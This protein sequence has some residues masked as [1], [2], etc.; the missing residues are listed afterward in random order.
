VAIDKLAGSQ[1]AL[2]ITLNDQLIPVDIPKKTKLF[3]KRHFPLAGRRFVPE[4]IDQWIRR[5]IAPKGHLEANSGPWI[6]NMSLPEMEL[7]CKAYTVFTELNQLALL[8]LLVPH[9]RPED[10]SILELHGL[11][12]REI[13]TLSYLPLGYTNKQIAMAMD[14]EEVTVKKHLKNAGEKLDAIGKTDT[15]YRAIQLK[16]LLETLSN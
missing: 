3:I 12:K 11:T 5:Q 9:N 1:K 7:Y 6:F 13:E 16:E 10:F 2:T 15:L 4:P 8:V 14:I